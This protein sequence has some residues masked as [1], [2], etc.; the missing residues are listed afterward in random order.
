MCIEN[1]FI[2]NPNVELF[3]LQ[4][5]IEALNSK[6]ECLNVIQRLIEKAIA[7]VNKSVQDNVIIDVFESTTQQ[8]LG[9]I[10]VLYANIDGLLTPSKEKSLSITA[11]DIKKVLKKDVVVN[12]KKIDSLLLFLTNESKKLNGV[13]SSTLEEQLTTTKKLEQFFVQDGS[14]DSFSDTARQ[15][16]IKLPSPN[17][18]CVD[19]SH[20]KSNQWYAWPED[21]E[22]MSG[23]KFKPKD[24]GIGAGEGWLSFIFGGELQGQNSTFDISIYNKSSEAFERW[25][26]KEFDPKTLVVRL[27]SHGTDAAIDISSEISEIVTQLKNFVETYDILN[28]TS[29]SNDDEKEIV[30]WLERYTSSLRK[31]ID[32][33]YSKLVIKGDLSNADLKDLMPPCVGASNIF[34]KINVR[35]ENKPSIINFCDRKLKLTFEQYTKFLLIVPDILTFNEKLIAIASVLKHDVLRGQQN[36]ADFLTTWLEKLK[37]S[38]AFGNVDGVFLTHKLGFI[39]V[40]KDI[41]DNVF[42][43]YRLGQGR[44]PNF[45]IKNIEQPKFLAKINFFGHAHFNDIVQEFT[46]PVPLS[47]TLENISVISSDDELF[48]KYNPWKSLQIDKT[49]FEEKANKQV[50]I[51]NIN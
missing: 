31:Y 10:K 18:C 15:D 41:V 27:G 11:D 24:S 21:I 42:D 28:L 12:K 23:N 8:T 16:F 25:E 2:F 45:K 49:F 13:L 26:V 47:G 9:E 43:Y 37:P 29:Y 50:K 22:Y 46:T 39:K 35:C 14:F 4:N 7:D 44:R 34:K 32:L 5:N 40:S 3:T 33:N 36:Y 1:S 30:D 48:P 51:I 6:V 17:R 38:K 19:I 20:I